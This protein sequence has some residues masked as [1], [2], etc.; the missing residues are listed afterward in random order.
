VFERKIK[1]E[2]ERERV[3][4]SKKEIKK[5]DVQREGEQTHTII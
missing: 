5:R 4:E 3:K 2:G 1:G